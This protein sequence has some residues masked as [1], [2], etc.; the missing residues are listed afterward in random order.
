ML[1]LNRSGAALATRYAASDHAERRLSTGGRDE[2]TLEGG[3]VRGSRKQLVRLGVCV[4]IQ[5]AWL[6]LTR[7]RW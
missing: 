3:R 1:H 5:R 2:E 7:T 6:Y 4:D